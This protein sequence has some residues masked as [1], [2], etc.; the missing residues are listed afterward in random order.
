MLLMQ[1]FARGISCR[2]PRVYTE[3]TIDAWHIPWYST[4]KYCI[5]GMY[6]ALLSII[7]LF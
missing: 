6:I 7:L 5:T 1:C 2:M 3:N 4:G